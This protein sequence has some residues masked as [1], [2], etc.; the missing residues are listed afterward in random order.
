LSKREII[1]TD[2]APKPGGAYSQAIRTENLVFVA[3]QLATNPETGKPVEGG[4][5]EQ[6][7][8]TLTNL[9]SIL[10]AAG[11]SLDLVVRVG[12]YLRDIADFSEMNK[13]YSTFFSKDPPARST[14]QAALPGSF[15][16]EIDV[17]ALTR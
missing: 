6:T 8:Q 15:L 17:I 3:G 11:S 4:I 16:V 13:V 10:E 7:R 14:I 12:V 9:K 5:V 2:K 1:R